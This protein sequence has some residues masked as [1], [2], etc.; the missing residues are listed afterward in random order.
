MNLHHEDFG[1]TKTSGAAGKKLAPV[2]SGPAAEEMFRQHEAAVRVGCGW[3]LK[4]RIAVLKIICQQI[5]L[6][7]GGII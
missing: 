2:K 6:P 5:F 1:I 4:K 3:I 7:F